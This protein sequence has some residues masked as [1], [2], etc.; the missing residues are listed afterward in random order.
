MSSEMTK[1]MQF[2]PWA[3]ICPFLAL[4]RD[5]IQ[6]LYQNIE[7]AIL[8]NNHEKK[9]GSIYGDLFKLSF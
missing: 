1:I 8:N 6:S 9:I 4:S 2:N 3:Q 7:N 5:I